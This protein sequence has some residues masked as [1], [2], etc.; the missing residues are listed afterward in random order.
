VDLVLVIDRTASAA[1]K[2]GTSPPRS[3]ETFGPTVAVIELYCAWMRREGWR[4]ALGGGLAR[5][6][7]ADRSGSVR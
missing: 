4:S 2:K 3:A 7:A 5:A 6:L 1:A